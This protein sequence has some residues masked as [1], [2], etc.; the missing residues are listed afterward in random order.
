MPPDAARVAWAEGD[1]ALGLGRFAEA[2]LA[3]DRVF[4][5]LG[6]GAY[7][8]H[9]VVQFNRGKA[10]LALRRQAEA[11]DAF[12]EAHNAMGEIFW[13]ATAS[14]DQVTKHVVKRKACKSCGL[15]AASVIY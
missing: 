2:V 11:L 4:A 6:K 13:G 9:L 3:Y 1:M 12:R 14:L 7:S 8:T 10:L 15:P 5:L